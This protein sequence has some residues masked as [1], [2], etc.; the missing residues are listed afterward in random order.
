MLFIDGDRFRGRNFLEYSL[1]DPNEIERIEIIRGP[2]AALYGSDAMNGLVNVIT[3]LLVIG[4][5]AL[6]AALLIA[7]TLEIR[8]A[9]ISGV[10]KDASGAVLPGVTVEAASPLDRS[11]AGQPRSRHRR[12]GQRRESRNRDEQSRCAALAAAE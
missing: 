11:A 6:T 1:L 5:I 2:A 7:A 9:V 10:V 4:Q 8:P 12:S 3:R